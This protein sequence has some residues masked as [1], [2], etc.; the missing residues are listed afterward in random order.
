MKQRVLLWLVLL[1]LSL[2]AQETHF[3]VAVV[4]KVVGQ[5]ERQSEGRPV[6]QPVRALQSLRE[7]DTL[8]LDS[9]ESLQILWLNDHSRY[10]LKGP[11]REVLGGRKSPP[12]SSFR[13]SQRQRQALQAGSNIDLRKYGDGSARDLGLAWQVTDEARV[14]LVLPPEPLSGLE[15]RDG[16]RRLSL[17]PITLTL[18][19]ELKPGESRDLRLI[20]RESEQTLRVSRLNLEDMAR[21]KLVRASPQNPQDW[22]ERIML[23]LKLR[24]AHR[25]VLDFHTFQQRF[26]QAAREL[27]PTLA[28]LLRDLG[29]EL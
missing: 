21:L 22:M 1:S 29:G 26:P 6:S 9:G 28:E 27:G 10:D 15:C 4:L 5:V 8:L 25:A 12:P 24:M 13:I 11:L 16:E 7:R 19:L 3:K 20:W 14:V 2:S 23:W 17:E 18:D